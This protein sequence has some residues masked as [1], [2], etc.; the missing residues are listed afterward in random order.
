MSMTTAGKSFGTPARFGKKDRVMQINQQ[1]R[2]SGSAALKK[3]VAGKNTQ[4]LKHTKASK[5]MMK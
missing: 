3:H 2:G 1:Q 5:G 4:M